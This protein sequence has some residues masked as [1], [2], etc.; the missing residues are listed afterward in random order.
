VYRSDCLTRASIGT[1][2]KRKRNKRRASGGR[3]GSTTQDEV[4][5][6]PKEVGETL[7]RAKPSEMRAIVRR[8][9]EPK[10]QLKS[11][12]EQDGRRRRGIGKNAEA[13]PES[14]ERA[15]ERAK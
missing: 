9:Y 6:V 2:V 12:K 11:W 8:G 14:S 15:G 7:C 5:Q 4:R 3:K 10:P 1:T 13:T